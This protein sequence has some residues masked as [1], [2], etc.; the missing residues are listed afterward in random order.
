MTKAYR[1][2]DF[3]CWHRGQPSTCFSKSWRRSD[4]VPLLQARAFE[5]V[6]ST[7]ALPERPSEENAWFR[8]LLSGKFRYFSEIPFWKLRRHLRRNWRQHWCRL[9]SVG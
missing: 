9:Q 2:A 7:Q 6:V 3:G 4:A 8:G 5:L 1:F